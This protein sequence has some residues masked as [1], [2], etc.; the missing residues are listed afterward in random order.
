MK[1]YSDNYPEL[2]VASEGKTQLRYNIEQH[3]GD[4][5]HPE[6]YW[7]FDWITIDASP[8]DPVIVLY[9]KA[10]AGKV[11]ADWMIDEQIGILRKFAAGLQLQLQALADNLGETLPGNEYSEIFEAFHNQVEGLKAATKQGLNIEP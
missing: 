10:V 8:D 5:D 3:E 11:N 4:D 9:Y 6:P 1:G 7:S 2:M